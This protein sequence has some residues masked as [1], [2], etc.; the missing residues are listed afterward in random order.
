MKILIIH[1]KYAQSG[2]EDAVVMQESVLLNQEHDVEV[3][4]F[5]NYTGIKGLFQFLHSMWN[6]SASR[7][8]RSK[9]NQ[10]KPDIVHLHN[11]HFASGP[12]IIRTVKKMGI[13]LVQTLHNYRVLC[14]S[15]ILLHNNQ[16][17]LDSLQADFP[18]S[19]VRKKVY[20]N[21]SI[22]TF[23]LAVVF[24]FH[25]RMGTFK[26]VDKYI[27]LTEYSKKMIENSRLDIKSN[28]LTIKPNFTKKVEVTSRSVRGNHFLFIGRLSAEKGI[29]ILL[30]AFENS[31]ETLKIGGDGPLKGLVEQKAKECSN[32]VYLGSLKSQQVNQQLCKAQALIFPSIWYEGMPMTI[33]EAFAVKTPVIGSNLGAMSSIIKDHTNGLH[34]EVG[35]V[36]DLKMKIKEW[37][38]FS[39]EQ[40]GKLRQQ[41]FNSY[42]TMYAPELQLKYFETIYNSVLKKCAKK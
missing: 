39:A 2:G 1:T 29:D 16:L 35:N 38:Q 41:A 15:A 20:K 21:S 28:Q 4:Y 30:N 19:A 42:Q 6:M 34:F 9:M 36:D 27:C 40:K 3:L 17:F 31:T 13:P 10:F 11:F 25:K 23:W 26:K 18:W 8:V 22:L 7:K 33:L 14:P 5:Q 37:I 32:I 12:L 24:W